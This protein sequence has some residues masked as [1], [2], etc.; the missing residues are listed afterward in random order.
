MVPKNSTSQPREHWARL[1]QHLRNPISLA[2]M[3]LAIVSLGNIFLFS[4][5][6]FIAE[7]PSPYIGILA[8]MVAPA[9]LVCGLFLMVVGAWRA[10]LKKAIEGAGE[11][12]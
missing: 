6:G 3:A 5:I 11:V 4:L 1:R 2:G 7:R 10:R 8:Y 9:F 12:P